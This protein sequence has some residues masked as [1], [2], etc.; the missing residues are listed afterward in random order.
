M[1][2]ALIAGPI[3]TL[4]SQ[5][6]IDELQAQ[7]IE[8][9]QI[10]ID[11]LKLTK[12]IDISEVQ[13]FSEILR[14]CAG[15]ASG[16]KE[17][18][19]EETFGHMQQQARVGEY[20]QELNNRFHQ[21]KTGT[22]RFAMVKEQELQESIRLGDRQ[23]AQTL[24][25]ELLGEIF[26]TQGNN[27]DMIRFRIMELAILLSRA[28][29]Q[30]GAQEEQVMEISYRF[31]KELA[32][33]RNTEEMTRWLSEILHQYTDLVFEKKRLAHANVMLQASHYIRSHFSEKI[34]LEAISMEVGMNPTY[35]SKLFNEEMGCSLSEYINQIR[36]EN[37][38]GLLLR[39]RYTLVEI[40]GCVG[41][42]DQGYFS[43]KFKQFAGV[44]PGSYRKRIDHFPKDNQ[45]I[46]TN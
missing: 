35:F 24:M 16:Y 38:K 44:T 34:S 19:M 30:G 4:E 33:W 43:R 8:L 37:A 21:G 2:Y 45:E 18:R 14:M 10:K 23:T 6:V 12:K 25:N 28:A 27:T 39:T 5:E 31:Q 46:H 13:S 9:T 20:I 40:A 36:I 7:G 26:F 41:Y 29:I 42:E 3:L 17:H 1:K 32:R 11:A 15:W 22:F